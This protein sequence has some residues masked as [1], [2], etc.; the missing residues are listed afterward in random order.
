MSPSNLII[1]DYFN[2]DFPQ[3]QELWKATGIYTEERGDSPEIITRCNAHG[4]KFLVI[5]DTRSGKICG[6]SWMSWDGRRIFLHH[7][8]V[9]PEIQGRGWGRKLAEASLAFA[10]EKGQPVKLEVHQD[11]LPAVKLY[12]SLGFRVFEG[13]DMYMILDP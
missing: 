12:R 3:V 10:R 11:N 1:R 6:T 4:G 9:A 8:A 2:P 13:Y 7:F 5:E